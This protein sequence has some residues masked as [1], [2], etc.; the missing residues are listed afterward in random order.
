LYSSSSIILVIEQKKMAWAGHVA[1]MGG[2]K[3][4]V[5]GKPDKKHYLEGLSVERRTTSK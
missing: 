3:H 5:V 1:H 4:A 2:I